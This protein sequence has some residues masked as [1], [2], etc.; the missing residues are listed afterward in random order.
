MTVL[1]TI[2]LIRHQQFDSTS[3]LRTVAY[4]IALSARQTQVYG[5]SVRAVDSLVSNPTFAPAYGLYFAGTGATTYTLF[6]DINNNGQYESANETIQIFTLTRGFT[7]TGA[8][9]VLAN[10]IRRCTAAS[11]DSSG[12][13]TI[14]H[15]HIL[16]KRPNPEA[17]FTAYNG[18]STIAGD[19]YTKGYVQVTSSG[20]N[21]RS[22]TVT[23]TGQISVGAIGS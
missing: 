16:F 22:M 20:G 1:S 12:G 5:T 14:T 21:T 17:V 13:A 15:V 8:C 10:D 18:A 7:I 11:L 2:L 4:S 3:L 23:N 9:A 19:T 6:A